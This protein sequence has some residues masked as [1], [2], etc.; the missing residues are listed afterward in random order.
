M[1]SVNVLP[2]ANGTTLIRPID[3]PQHKK[4]QHNPETPNTKRVQNTSLK[5]PNINIT[6]SKNLKT[7]RLLNCSKL[8]SVQLALHCN[9][10]FARVEV[11]TEHL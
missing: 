9:W 1:F 5:I 7:I 4:R 10:Q 11:Q 6:Q 8:P 3:F 2:G